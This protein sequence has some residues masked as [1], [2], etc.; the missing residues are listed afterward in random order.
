MDPETVKLTHLTPN[1]GYKTMPW[2]NG[3]G[4]TTE[5][6]VER[7]AA[8]E[9]LWRVSIADVKQSGPFSDFTGYDRTIMLLEGRGFVLDFDE[10][11]RQRIDR[12][13]EPFRFAGEWKTNC[14][15]IDGP[16]RDF[17]LMVAR[18][19]PPGRVECRRLKPG[20]IRL[21]GAQTVLVHAIS[22]E[23]LVCESEIVSGDT[24]RIDGAE[25]ITLTT[26]SPH[27]IAAI[28]W[29]GGAA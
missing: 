8:G 14:T 25:E 7:E 2:K 6:T 3:G 23:V 21:P 15:L 18:S 26:T 13:W 28:V 4:M 1:R 11:P 20:T 16:V 22:A 17:N 29:I 24:M 12:P 10:A 9:V 19:G 27:N 5:V